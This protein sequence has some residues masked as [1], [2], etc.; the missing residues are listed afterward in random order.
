M[1]AAQRERNQLRNLFFSPLFSTI[2]SWSE[3][4]QQWE[5]TVDFLQGEAPLRPA[6]NDRS[7]AKDEVVD[8]WST[9]EMCDRVILTSWKQKASH[10]LMDIV[11]GGIPGFT[12][13]TKMTESTRGLQT[14][15]CLT[16][17][18]AGYLRLEANERASRYN[19]LRL[20]YINHMERIVKLKEG[21]KWGKT[22][23][24]C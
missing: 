24:Q 21:T 11:I 16:A 20:Y 10:Y 15:M 22:L 4:N 18:V 2:S 19:K 6:I 5:S 1:P 17:W 8:F 13:V 14:S 3:R 7:F 9:R 12:F 23:G